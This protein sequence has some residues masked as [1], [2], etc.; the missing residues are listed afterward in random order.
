MSI[1]IGR[2]FKHFVKNKFFYSLI[3]LAFFILFSRIFFIHS[4][5]WHDDAFNFVD[6]ALKLALKGEYV[7]AHSTGYPAWLLILALFLKISYFFTNQWEIIFVPNLVTVFFSVFLVFPLY[8]LANIFLKNH[9]FSFFATF[10]ILLNPILWRWSTV[11]MSDIFALFCILYSFLFFF[12]FL[13]DDFKKYLFLSNIFLYLALMTRLIYGLILFVL[14]FILWF[15]ETKYNFKKKFFISL[16]YIFNI[17]FVIFSYLLLNKF[18]INILVQNYGSVWPNFADI[19]GTLEIIFRSIGPIFLCVLPFG[20]FYFYQKDKK[21]FYIF[22]S[23]FVIFCLYLASWYK[24]GLFDI[25]RYALLLIPFLMIVSFGALKINKIFK[26]TFTILFLCSSIFLI[27]AFK[28]PLSTYATYLTDNNLFSD[29][30]LKYRQIFQQK[31]IDGDLQ[32]YKN[33]STVIQEGD[34]VFH[35]TNDW[36]MPQLFL[37]RESLPIKAKLI[38]IN[39]QESLQEALQKYSGQKIYFLRGVDEMYVNFFSKN[40]KAEKLILTDGSFVYYIQ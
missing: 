11:A 18:D 23:I 40:K 22:I 1:L 21:S 9:Y 37:A 12:F 5:L 30:T 4:S 36:S 13:R 32:K 19:F 34:L 17:V 10:S 24:N 25:E 8:Q 15:L 38:A 20:L 2:L 39:S 3:L 29:F 6:K 31:L 28:Q 26:F 33:L 16:S 35:W 14:L 7:N 27:F